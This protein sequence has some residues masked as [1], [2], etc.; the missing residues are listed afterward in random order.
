MIINLLDNA[1]KY[2]MTGATIVLRAWKQKKEIYISIKDNGKGIP[3]KDLPY[4]FHRFY[5]VDKSRTRAL[6]GSGL[7]LSITKE[8][9]TAHGGEILVKSKENVGTECELIFKEDKN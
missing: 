1:R 5:R 8:L 2:S 9:M 7:G 3:E 6:G 4:I